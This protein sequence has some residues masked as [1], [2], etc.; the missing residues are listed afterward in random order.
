MASKYVE[1]YTRDQVHFGVQADFLDAVALIIIGDGTVEG[2]LRGGFGRVNCDMEFQMKRQR[3]ADHIKSRTDIG[4][5]A[6]G[7]EHEGGCSH[8]G[9]DG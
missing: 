1:S 2:M 4:R 5:G 9:R 3:Q 8:G 7:F 6:G